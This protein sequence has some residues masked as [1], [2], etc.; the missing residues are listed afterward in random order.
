MAQFLLC[1]DPPAGAIGR[2]LS[3]KSGGA[4]PSESVPPP[5]FAGSGAPPQGRLQGDRRIAQRG[6][7]MTRPAVIVDA[8]VV[9]VGLLT[10]HEASPVARI[11]DSMLAAALPF[12]PQTNRSASSSSCRILG[13]HAPHGMCQEAVQPEE[14]QVQRAVLVPIARLVALRPAAAVPDGSGSA[15]RRASN[16]LRGAALDGSAF[17]GRRSLTLPTLRCSFAERHGR[18]IVSRGFGCG[19][20]QWGTFW[21]T[22]MKYPSRTARIGEAQR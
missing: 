12:I 15:T 1:I 16:L 18:A 14:P 8:D 21:G 13:P 7:S 11:S 4:A 22:S 5:A 17:R 6:S 9:V 19:G 2:T 10:V 20:L 3:D